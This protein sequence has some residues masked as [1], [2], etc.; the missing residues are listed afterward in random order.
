MIDMKQERL[1]EQIPNDRDVFTQLTSNRMAYMHLSSVSDKKDCFTICLDS[2]LQ[3]IAYGGKN[4][5]QNLC[6]FVM[7][8]PVLDYKQNLTV[9]FGVVLYFCI[10][11]DLF[12]V[13]E[14]SMIVPSMRQM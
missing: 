5:F 4:S 6:R 1:F 14:S 8:R 11:L 12:F 7:V 10:N 2:W 9:C 3:L 13:D